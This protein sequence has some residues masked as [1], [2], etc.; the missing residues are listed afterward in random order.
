MIRSRGWAATSSWSSCTEAGAE[1]PHATR[2]AILAANQVLAALRTAFELGTLR[3]VASASVGVVVFDG[4]E[5]RPDELLKRA[6]IAMYQ[7]KGAGRNGVALFDPATMDRETE[8]Y[9]LMSD[10]RAGLAEGQLDLLF[11]AAGRP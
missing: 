5:K 6:D 9:Q 2:R 7:A 8:R 3:H 1:R 4:Q 10:L 11:P